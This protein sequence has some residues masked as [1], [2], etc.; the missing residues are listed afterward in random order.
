M[1]NAVAKITTHSSACRQE[2]MA[3]EELN[4]QLMGNLSPAVQAIPYSPEVKI[5]RLINEEIRGA[6]SGMDT[7]SGAS[8]METDWVIP[9]LRNTRVNDAI[10]IPLDHEV[11]EQRQDSV[12]Q[13]SQSQTILQSG[14]FPGQIGQMYT[15][16]HTASDGC[17]H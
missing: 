2:E 8:S 16:T 3:Q 14:M 11:T 7:N 12:S 13:M 6:G 4:K 1:Y 15:H 17:G 10:P 9:D 5:K